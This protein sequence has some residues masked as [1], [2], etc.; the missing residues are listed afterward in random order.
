M[1][2]GVGGGRGLM[3]ARFALEDAAAGEAEAAETTDPDAER[4]E[5]GPPHAPVRLPALLDGPE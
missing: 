4:S 2:T 1:G 5:P 3:S